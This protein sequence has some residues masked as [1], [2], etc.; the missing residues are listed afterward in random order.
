M[1]DRRA[2]WSAYMEW[3]K[4]ETGSAPY[5]LANS[6][7]KAYSLADLD[8]GFGSLAL[9]GPGAYGH[10]PLVE[11]LAAKCNVAADCIATAQGTSMANH[12]AM[13]AILEPG[14]DVLIEHPAYPLLWETAE[15]LGAR[16]RFFERPAAGEFALDLDRL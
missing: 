7:V 2:A 6:G 14:D 10:A 1:R 13:A 15:Y 4:T 3:V 12:L 9:C 11:A 5:N 16:V 8:V